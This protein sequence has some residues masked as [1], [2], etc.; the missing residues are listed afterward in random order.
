MGVKATAIGAEAIAKAMAM[1]QLLKDHQLLQ[2]LY[3]RE[4]PWE[5]QPREK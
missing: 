3:T 5:Q 4:A 1:K 2:D